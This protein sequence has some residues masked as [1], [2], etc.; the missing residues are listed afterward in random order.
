MLKIYDVICPECGGVNTLR[1]NRHEIKTWTLVGVQRKQ[2]PV[3]LMNPEN[4]TETITRLT[5]CT[6]P[7]C[8]WQTADIIKASDICREPKDQPNNQEAQD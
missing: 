8:S 4:K 3:L 2:K 5:T 1:Y 6:A 7:G